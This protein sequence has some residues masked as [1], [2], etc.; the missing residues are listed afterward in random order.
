MSERVLFSFVP[1][2]GHQRKTWDGSG[3]CC[4]KEEADNHYASEIAGGCMTSYEDRP[5][6]V[7][8]SG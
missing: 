5:S 1:H 4:S 7:K 2:A 8:Y 3:F 6:N